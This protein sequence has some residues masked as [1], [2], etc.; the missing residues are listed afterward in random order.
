MAS[1]AIGNDTKKKFLIY[2]LPAL[3]YAGLIITASS[4][5]NLK[6]PKIANFQFD[7]VAHFIEYALFAFLIYRSVINWG[8]RMLCNTALVISSILV[9]LFAIMD[10]FY[11]RYVPG[12]DSG[13]PDLI[14]DLVGAALVLILLWYRG[15]STV[16]K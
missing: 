10:E 7:K 8:Q 9:L 4:I 15:K 1:D 12:R 13:I 3:I 5:P 6:T 2:H 14:T 11:Q 16:N